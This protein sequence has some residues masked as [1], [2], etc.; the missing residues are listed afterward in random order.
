MG[1]AIRTVDTK[2][3]EWR[4]FEDV[5]Q[6]CAKPEWPG[7]LN[8]TRNA[9]MSVHQVDVNATKTLWNEPPV[10][11]EMFEGYP[12]T[13]NFT[14]GLWE[15]SNVLVDQLGNRTTVAKALELSAA[16]RWKFDPNFNNGQPSQPCSGNGQVKLTNPGLWVNYDKEPARSDVS[17]ECLPGWSGTECETGE[18]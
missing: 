16:I 10:Q 18:D 1:Y 11:R 3:V 6:D 4:R 17:C 5:F 7:L 8:T 14:W 13:P 12:T 2:Y 15:L 9:M